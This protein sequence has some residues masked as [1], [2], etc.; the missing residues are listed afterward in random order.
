MADVAEEPLRSRVG[1]GLAELQLVAVEMKA[2]ADLARGRHLAVV[3]DLDPVVERHRTRERLT[4]LRMVALYRSGRQV[5]ALAEYR[6]TRDV[7]V[8][9]LGVEPGEALRRLQRQI[10]AGRSSA[11]L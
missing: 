7:L 11:V 6:R 5:D 1:T 4:E 8:D 3:T 2:D 10:L 9:E